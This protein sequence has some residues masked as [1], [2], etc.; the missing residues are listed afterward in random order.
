MSVELDSPPKA[1]FLL[2]IPD[3]GSPVE[4][5]F[6]EVSGLTGRMAE[7]EQAR[8]DGRF[9][10]EYRSYLG[11][12]VDVEEPRI[13]LRVRTPEHRIV[14]VSAEIPEQTVLDESVRDALDF[15]AVG[16]N[17]PPLDTSSNV[18]P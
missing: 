18:G 10:G 4:E 7:L 12:K 14:E 15:K 8:L 6:D 13:T 9:S 3:V 11:W 2:L 1:Y 17:I 5:V 16:D